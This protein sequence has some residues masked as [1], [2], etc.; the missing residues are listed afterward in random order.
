LREKE[1]ALAGLHGALLI[2]ILVG[3]EVYAVIECF[4]REARRPDP[5]VID[6]ATTIGRQI[7]QFLQRRRA[8]ADLRQLNARLEERVLARTAE[9]QAVNK[10]LE[11]FAYS[12]SHDLRA[13]LRTIDGFSQMIAEDYGDQIGHEGKNYVSRI[14][15]AARHMGGLI[16]DLLRLSRLMRQELH[17]RRVSLSALARSVIADLERERPR[18]LPVTVT[19]SDGLSAH[20]DER[21]LRLV[22]HNLL[23]NAWKFTGRTPEAEIRVGME[24]RDGTPVFFVR[25][26]GV[27]F[28]MAYADKLFDPFQRF[29]SAR[30]FEGSGIGLATVQRV[31]QR[32]GGRVWA[33]GK[34]GEGAAFYFTL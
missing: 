12:V 16:D 32:H 14:R 29:H 34:P 22:L 11:A 10:E 23:S 21:L 17:P 20:G 26:N 7:G 1:A 2:P 28:D 9:L 33:E 4:S 15:A 24:R 30:E 6:M 25:D 18:D 8:E 19:V 13:P 3:E 5:D 27:G 31:I